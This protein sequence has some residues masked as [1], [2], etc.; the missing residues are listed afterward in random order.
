[1]FPRR[2]GN[3]GTYRQANRSVI[4]INDE[5]LVG[6]ELHIAR[7]ACDRKNF[8][9][10]EQQLPNWTVGPDTFDEEYRFA[11]YGRSPEGFEHSLNEFRRIRCGS[12]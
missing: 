12:F 10:L 6:L 2:D 3:R 9:R 1:V 7:S 11:N 8:R 4:G 5:I